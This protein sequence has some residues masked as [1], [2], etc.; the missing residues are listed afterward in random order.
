MGI[1]QKTKKAFY[2]IAFLCLVYGIVMEFVQRYYIT[3]RSFDPGDIIADG[4][5]CITGLIFSIKR[6]IKK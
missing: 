3:N 6:Y 1:K 4:M 5:G 2:L